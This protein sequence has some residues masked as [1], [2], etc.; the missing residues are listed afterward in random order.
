[1]R[2]PGLQ[3]QTTAVFPG[4]F[5]AEFSSTRAN[6]RNRTRAER[7]VSRL[8]EIPTLPSLPYPP[9]VVARFPFLSHARRKFDLL[10]S[11]PFEIS[12]PPRSSL[13]PRLFVASD[14][15]LGF[16]GRG[17]REGGSAR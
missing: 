11:P 13:N 5:A 1:M 12:F 2:T 15:S 17:K 6:T 8:R 9:L 16:D 10:A 3:R 7:A 4:I 14:P